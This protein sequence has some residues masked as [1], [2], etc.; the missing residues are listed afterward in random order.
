[1]NSDQIKEKKLDLSSV[2]LLPIW[3]FMIGFS[4]SIS[5]H[6]FIDDGAKVFQVWYLFSFYGFVSSLL[7]IPIIMITRGL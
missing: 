2:Y 6:Y 7:S 4:I 1:M 5:F 3:L